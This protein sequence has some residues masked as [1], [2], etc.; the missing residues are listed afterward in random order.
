MTIDQWQRELAR[1]AP[2]A[3][4]VLED[5]QDMLAAWQT[6]RAVLLERIAALTEAVVEVQAL[7][8][9]LLSERGLT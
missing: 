2:A 7:A 4:F 8:T 5:L 6:D 1:C 3:P 9:K